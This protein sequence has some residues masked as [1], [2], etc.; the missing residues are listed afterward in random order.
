MSRNKGE[1]SLEKI[2]DFKGVE[3]KSKRNTIRLII[4]SLF[5]FG[6]IL[7]YFKSDSLNLN[8]SKSENTYNIKEDKNLDISKK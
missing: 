5:V 2:D 3:S 8:N 7:V 4:L 1:P 6:A